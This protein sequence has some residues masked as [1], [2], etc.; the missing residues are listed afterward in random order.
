MKLDKKKWNEIRK[1][2]EKNIKEHKVRQRESHQPRWRHGP[3]DHALSNMK[4]DATTL[5]AVRAAVRGKQHCAT[6]PVQ[7]AI[8]K[9]L[10]Q[11]ALPEE[12]KPIDSVIPPQV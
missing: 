7:D 8:D 1:E 9:I 3:D 12:E 11:Y 6:W 5:Y 10:P 4:W 2:V